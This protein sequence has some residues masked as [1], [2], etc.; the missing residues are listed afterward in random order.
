[1][2]EKRDTEKEQ[3]DNARKRPQPSPKSENK[4][5]QAVKGR[6]R[7]ANMGWHTEGK[8]CWVNE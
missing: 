6:K 1:M 8:R 4:K 2:P 7:S 5:R 3:L